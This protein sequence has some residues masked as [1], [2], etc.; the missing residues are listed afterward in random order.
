MAAAGTHEQ[1]IASCAAYRAYL[2][3]AASEIQA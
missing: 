1:L 3:H 2:A